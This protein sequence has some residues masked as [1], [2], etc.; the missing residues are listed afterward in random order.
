MATNTL[1]TNCI[2]TVENFFKIFLVILSVPRL[3]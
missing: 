3:F 2:R 1:A